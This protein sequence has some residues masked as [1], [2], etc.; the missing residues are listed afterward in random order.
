MGRKASG[1][2]DTKRR[3]ARVAKDLS[4][5]RNSRSL[6]LRPA[7]ARTA[8]ETKTRD[9]ARDDS[10]RSAAGGLPFDKLPSFVRAGGTSREE[11]SLVGP[12][13]ASLGMTILIGSS[14]DSDGV[15]ER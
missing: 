12:G 1:L 2:P 7:P 6:E 11:R 15:S 4:Y 5:I 10:V 8:G 14:D 9:S 13:S 3:D